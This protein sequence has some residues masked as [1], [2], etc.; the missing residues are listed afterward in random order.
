MAC[1]RGLHTIKEWD[2][3]CVGWAR[4]L[5]SGKQKR[6]EPVSKWLSIILK[7]KLFTES[8]AVIVAI[9]GLLSDNYC[10]KCILSDLPVNPSDLGGSHWCD[11]RWL[12]TGDNRI[13]YSL[14][15]K[16]QL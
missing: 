11:Q 16:S 7:G 6:R 1:N 8:I 10:H 3:G 14:Q 2:N 12:T 15:Y 13:N 4:L 9:I 5:S